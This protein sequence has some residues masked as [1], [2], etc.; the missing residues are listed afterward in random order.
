MTH[1]NFIF[2]KKFKV[3]V[4]LYTYIMY[5][6]VESMSESGNIYFV[7]PGGGGG[8]IRHGAAHGRRGANHDAAQDRRHQADHG[9]GG[10]HCARSQI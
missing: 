8:W 1:V 9:A 10:E 5:S 2:L 3:T 4:P 6:K 7:T